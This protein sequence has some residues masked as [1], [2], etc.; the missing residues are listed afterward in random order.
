MNDKLND[1]QKALFKRIKELDNDNKLLAAANI[2]MKIMIDSLNDVISVGIIDRINNSIDFN[3]NGEDLKY[4]FTVNNVIPF[5]IYKNVE[6][7]INSLEI[8]N[9]QFID[10]H[11]VDNK[12]YPISF[13]ITNTNKYINVYDIDSYIIPEIKP[14][15]LKLNFFQKTFKK[16][17]DSPTWF[18]LGA[19]S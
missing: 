14:K 18:K 5:N 4:N 10:F 13:S 11:Y 15:E 9:E 19:L 8:P 2:R 1:N 12:D 3:Y 6:H 7:K 16:I 17:K